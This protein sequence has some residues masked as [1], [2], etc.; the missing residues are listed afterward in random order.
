MEQGADINAL[1]TNGSSVLMMA[2]YEGREELA[3]M[4]IEKGAERGFRNDWGDGALEWAMRYN[5]LNIAR[6]I[7]NPEE[8]NIAINKPKETWGEPTRSLRMSKELEELVEMREKLVERGESTAAIDKRINVERV[9]VMRA[10]IDRPA[11]PERAATMEITASRKAPKEQSAR[12]IYDDKGKAASKK[13][14]VGSGQPKAQSNGKG[15]KE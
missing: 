10:E 6:M 3:R 8:F 15:A 1:S 11:T 2:I 7:T 9:R 12:I 13:A 5:Q 4:L 14:A